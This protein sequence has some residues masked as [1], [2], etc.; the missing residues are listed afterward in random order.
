MTV[1]RY[2]GLTW[3]H[4][5]GHEPL[6]ASVEAARDFGIEV[7]W[8]VQA[9]EGFESHPIGELAQRYDLL[10]V[11]HPHCGDIAAAGCIRP[12][13]EVFGADSARCWDAEAAG[14]SGASYWY[15]GHHWAAPLDAATQVSALLADQV[16]T[17]PD[18]WDEALALAQRVPTLMPLAGPHPVL[19]V[20]SIA[21]ARGAEPGVD[22]LLPRDIGCMAYETWAAVVAA[23]RPTARP[24]NPIGVLDAM[25]QDKSAAV[26]CPLIYGYVTYSQ[27]GTRPQPVRFAEAPAAVPGGRRG[28]TLGGTGLAISRRT[29]LTDG[30]I[31]YCRW[32]M[33]DGTQRRFIPQHG[34]QPALR[35]AWAD[36]TVNARCDG[37]YERTRQTIEQAWV[38]PRFVGFT[39]FQEESSGL[40]REALRMSRSPV[41]VVDDLNQMYRR[42]RQNH[43]E[44]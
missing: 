14:A 23:C 32:L 13:E 11:D 16:P 31:A 41:A 8:K 29:P 12:I 43:R 36:A 34:G 15:F 2:C 9:L 28:S 5:R 25:S 7:D 40:L 19:T 4:P 17:A 33:S 6:R 44:I 42:Y 1:L 3:D 37:F 38:R 39:R 10:I 22:E 26:Y 27:P 21:V 20:L 24:L 35:S 30:L 18:T